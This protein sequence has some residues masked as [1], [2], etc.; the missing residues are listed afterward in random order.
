MFAALSSQFESCCQVEYGDEQS[1]LSG[2]FEYSKKLQWRRTATIP[3]SEPAVPDFTSVIKKMKDDF[4][5]HTGHYHIDNGS[6][7]KWLVPRGAQQ[8]SEWLVTSNKM[9]TPG[10]AV[11]RGFDAIVRSDSS[12]WLLH[13]TSNDGLLSEHHGH[14]IADASPWL[15]QSSS[16]ERQARPSMTSVASE[17]DYSEWLNPVMEVEKCQPWLITTIPIKEDDVSNWLQGHN[18]SDQCNEQWL[19]PRG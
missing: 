15:L 10:E 6:L 1:P 8:Q 7:E 14:F 19:S 9:D 5:N 13:S 12:L 2:W 3:S 18:W 16:T 11:T 17:Q 4:N